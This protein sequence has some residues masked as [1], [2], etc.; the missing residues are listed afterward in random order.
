MGQGSPPQNQSW[1]QEYR[2]S[3]HTGDPNKK[4]RHDVGAVDHGALSFE[5][6][7]RTIQVILGMCIVSSIALVIYGIVQGGAG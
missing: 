3:K 4:H 6:T 2:V 7:T 1:R 5:H